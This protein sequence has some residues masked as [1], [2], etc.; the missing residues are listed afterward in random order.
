MS[1]LGI[2]M[3]A[4]DVEARKSGS[5]IEDRGISRAVRRAILAVDVGRVPRAHGTTAAAD[6][7]RGTRGRPR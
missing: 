1:R 7:T 2:R 4:V 5:R 6:V 3:R